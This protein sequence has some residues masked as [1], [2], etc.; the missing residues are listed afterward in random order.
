VRVL[1][2]PEAVFRMAAEEVRAAARAA[3]E[4]RDRFVLALS[5]G[6]TPRGLYALLAGDPAYRAAIPWDRTHVFWGDERHV[7]PDHP[8]SNYRMAREVLLDCVPLPDANVHRV[9][10][11]DGDAGRAAARY[12]QDLREFFRL[13]EAALPQFDLVLLGLG[14]DGHTASLFPG[15]RALEEMTRLVVATRPP[16]SGADRITLTLPVLNHAACVTFLVAGAD[17][18]PVVRVVLEENPRDALLPAQRVRPVGRLL[19]LL[20]SAAAGTR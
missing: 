14:P 9:F 15:A 12:E 18:A 1:P 17:K 11:E 3:V 7:P 6:H 19:W 4:R 20:D 5:G 13:E 2:D 10:A 16:A 8:D